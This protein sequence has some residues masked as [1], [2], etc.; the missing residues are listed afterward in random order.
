MSI[1]DEIQ[2][3]DDLRRSGALSREEFELAKQRVLAGEADYAASEHMEEIKAQNAVAQLD[4]EWEMQRENYM[5]TGKYGAR[6]KPTRGGS[7]IGGIVIALFGT[8][9]TA[10]ASSIPAHA[11]VGIGVVFPLFGVLFI[12][13][14]V[15]SAIHSF[16]KA[17]SYEKA[18]QRY[19]RR[20]QELLNE[21]Q[22]LPEDDGR[23]VYRD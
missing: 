7:V 8:F 3:L 14:G 2:R 22:E 10:L 20:R 6:Y 21:H 15:G 16:T 1:S 23:S 13:L 17:D 4:R 5:V 19:Q 18:E 9:W 11:P 12:V